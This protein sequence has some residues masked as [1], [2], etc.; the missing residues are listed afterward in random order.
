MKKVFSL[1]M[2]LAFVMGGMAQNDAEKPNKKVKT[3]EK[4]QG[5]SSRSKQG[6]SRD[7]SQKKN[8]SKS[9]SKSKE[10]YPKKK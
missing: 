9:K 5:K 4:N 8:K 1:L 6:S 7:K 10:T 3:P 2:I